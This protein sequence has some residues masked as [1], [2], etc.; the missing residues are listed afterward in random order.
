[1]ES[2][3]GHTLTE[4]KKGTSGIIHGTLNPDDPEDPNVQVFGVGI[5]KLSA[6][7]K[8]VEKK[9]SDLASR[10]KRGDFELIHKQISD[11]KSILRHMVQAI[12]DVE[13]KLKTP[14]MKRKI[15]M[16]KRNTQ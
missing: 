13:D 5:W 15:T 2:F 9:I 8:N 3:I 14:Q 10:A 1:M 6:L 4:G 12:I 16:I 11:E 7:K